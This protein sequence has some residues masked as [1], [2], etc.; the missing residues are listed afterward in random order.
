M[1]R[2]IYWVLLKIYFAAF[3]I[4]FLVSVIKYNSYHSDDYMSHY[5]RILLTCIC[6]FTNIAYWLLELIEIDYI[7]WDWKLLKRYYF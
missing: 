2:E 6:A 1:T 3:V 5:T 4:P 7:G